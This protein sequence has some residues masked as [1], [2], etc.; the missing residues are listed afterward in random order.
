M[1]TF[2]YNE[3]PS[4]DLHRLRVVIGDTIEDDGPAP[5]RQNLSDELLQWYLDEAGSIPCAAAAIFEHLATRWTSRPIFGPGELSTT[6]VNLSAKFREQAD[7]WREQCAGSSTVLGGGDNVRSGSIT[8]RDAFSI[9][10]G[11][12]EYGG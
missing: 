3:P 1:S 2:T 12:T 9:A 4:S 7:Y 6:H 5:N 8:R 11:R 10:P